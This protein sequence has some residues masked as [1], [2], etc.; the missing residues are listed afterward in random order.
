MYNLRTRT[1]ERK[2]IFCKICNSLGKELCTICAKPHL[3][4]WY[5]TKKVPK[6]NLM[7]TIKI[8]RVNKK[9]NII[10]FGTKR[11]SEE[12]MD[13]EL[14]YKRIMKYDESS[15]Y[16]KCNCKAPSFA[17]G[18]VRAKYCDFHRGRINLTLLMKITKLPRVWIMQNLNPSIRIYKY[19]FVILFDIKNVQKILKNISDNE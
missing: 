8:L 14:G 13:L 9:F 5:S 6:K 12:W 3:A 4:S 7:N 18:R 16:L 17:T 10:T 19:H 2:N 15:E 11:F 1:V